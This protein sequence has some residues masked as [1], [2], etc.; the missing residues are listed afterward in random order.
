MESR[1][2]LFEQIEAYLAGQMLEP[3]R[4]A[5][6]ARI[7]QDLKFA[8][9]VRLHADL[10]RGLNEPDIDKLR[11]SI[12]KVLR[13][14]DQPTVPWIREYRRHLVA[15]C[16]TLIVAVIAIVQFTNKPTSQQL[17]T[18]YFEPYP[19]VLTSRDAADLGPKLLEAMA[20]Y[21]RQEYEEA[22]VLF[23][24]VV[25][26]GNV[27]DLV[28]LY[29]G[30]NELARGDGETA[31]HSLNQVGSSIL[32]HDVGWYQVLAQLKMG[33]EEKAKRELRGLLEAEFKYSTKAGELL[34]QL[35]R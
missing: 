10:A 2:A 8:N 27:S 3:D 12:Q 13:R 6:E 5:F 33:N 15:A 7:A 23:E 24:Q 35:T 34:E 21:N 25:E 32:E 4:L 20:L 26:A 11:A 17:F 31:N 29:Y 16:I 18:R 30:V 14:D 19:D 1:E 22:S 28:F 9:E